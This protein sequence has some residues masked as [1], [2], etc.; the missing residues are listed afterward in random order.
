ML[1][2]EHSVELK[3]QNSISSN[4]WKPKKLYEMIQIDSIEEVAFVKLLEIV[5]FSRIDEQTRF[6]RIIE[7]KFGPFNEKSSISRNY[8]KRSNS[9]YWKNESL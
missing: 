7:N 8:W 1:E 2:M 3:N 6:H 4:I 9:I 5:D